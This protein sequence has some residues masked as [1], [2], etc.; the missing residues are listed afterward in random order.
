MSTTV[1]SNIRRRIGDVL[2]HRGIITDEQ[3]DEAIRIHNSQ[4][5][6]EKKRLGNIIIE[7]LGV[8]RHQVMRT[9]ADLYAFREVLPSGEVNNE[10]VAQVK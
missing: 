5:S 4:K 9:L 7:D 2:V 8:D 1:T 3:L 6:P 10:L